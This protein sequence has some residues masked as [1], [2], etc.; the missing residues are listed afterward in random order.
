VLSFVLLS[1]IVYGT[2]VAAA[3]KHGG[4]LD[5]NQPSHTA[6]FSEPGTTTTINPGL[7]GC[8]ECLICQLHQNFSTS[9]VVERDGSFPPRTSLKT[10][11]STSQVIQILTASTRSG[12]APPFTS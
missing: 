11:Q 8:G 9:L 4:V 10:S 7:A 2:T 1:F 6:A 5:A 3:H 12:R